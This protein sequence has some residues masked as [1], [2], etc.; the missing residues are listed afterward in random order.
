M[1]RHA[2]R[3]ITILSGFLGSGKTTLLRRYL[4]ERASGD[5]RVIINEYGAVGIDHHLA[6]MVEDQSILLQGGCVCCGRREE[7]VGALRDL[8]D[9]EHGCAGAVRQV[10]IETSGLADPVPVMFS[11]AT[12]PVLRHQ[13]DVPL[14]VVTLA[15]IDAEL[16]IRRHEEVRKQIIAA[17]RVII[18]KSDL[19]ARQEVARCRVAVR[20]LNPTARIIVSPLGEAF[21]ALASDEGQEDERRWETVPHYPTSLPQP[22]LSVRS[23]SLTFDNP[24]DWMSFGVWLSM[25]LHVHGPNVLRIKGLLNIGDAG[26]VVMNV[27]QHVVHPPEHL[28]AWPSDDHRSILVFITRV[29]DPGRIAYSLE[30]FQHAAGRGDLRVL[31][32]G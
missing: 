29:I 25:L 12:D 19:T 21:E 11:L 28:P 18:T 31:R 22:H 15:A 8:L 5:I 27:A 3:A 20:A 14:V 7:L 30:T 16:H 13:F 1:T 32:P 24:L 2:R 9:Q 4:A 23:T 6:R 10:V 26:P 17:D